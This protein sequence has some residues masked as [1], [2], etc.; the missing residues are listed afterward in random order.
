MNM[1][2][3]KDVAYP[4]DTRASVNVRNSLKLFMGDSKIS[5]VYGDNAE[6]F[7]AALELLE[8]WNAGPAATRLAGPGLPRCY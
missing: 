1:L 8:T 6:E 5:L 7:E 3:V 2:T 4:V